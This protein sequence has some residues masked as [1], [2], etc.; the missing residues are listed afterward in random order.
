MGRR[1]PPPDPCRGLYAFQ[2][3]M[4]PF[5]ISERIRIDESPRRSHTGDEAGNRKEP[6]AARSTVMEMHLFGAEAA[7]EKALCGED[8]SAVE[9]MSVDYYLEGR[10]CG[11]V[12]GTV[13]DRCKTMAVPLAKVTLGHMAQDLEDEN[14]LGDADDCR[15]LLSRLARETELDRGP[16]RERGRSP[17]CGPLLLFGPI[18]VIG[19]FVHFA[20]RSAP[21]RTD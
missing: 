10:L 13:C 1:P 12:A 3:C 20:G 11:R 6:G 7:E 14:R 16:D 19:E 8:S 21:A 15:E 17:M 18:P 5:C 2:A 4:G 9:R